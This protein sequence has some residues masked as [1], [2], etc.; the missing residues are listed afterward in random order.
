VT[1]DTYKRLVDSID[2][3]EELLAEEWLEPDPKRADW[4]LIAARSEF[5][6]R[7]F[8]DKVLA[9]VPAGLEG[10]PEAE[11]AAVRE[12]VV[13]LA[14]D[15][16]AVA[17]ASGDSMGADWV[18]S[19]AASLAAP[20]IA[21]ELTAARQELP[22]FV[23]IRH[24]AWLQR[25]GRAV[26]AAPRWMQLRWST[27]NAALL[28]AMRRAR[29]VPDAGVRRG[30]ALGR[31][32]GFGTGLYGAREKHGDGSYLSTLCLSA[33]WIPILPLA[34]YRVRPFGES[35]ELLGREPLGSMARLWASMTVLLA[36]GFCGLIGLA[37]HQSSPGYEFR[38]AMQRAQAAEK[39]GNTKG[40]ANQYRLAVGTFAGR[41]DVSAAV[42]AAVRLKAGVVTAPCRADS[43]PAVSELVTMF[44]AFPAAAR[45]AA[46]SERM[47][48]R[49]ETC[50][51]EI[52]EATIENTRA[53]LVVVEM[54]HGVASVEARARLS[55]RG[56]EM[57]RTL[58]DAL[59]VDRPLD[60]LFQHRELAGD[61][62]AR[63]SARK[64]L[65]GFGDASALWA[66]AAP[67]IRAW[68]GV[69]TPAAGAPAELQSRLE[70]A[71][72]A[73]ADFVEVA[74]AGNEQDLTRALAAHPGSHTLQIALAARRRAEGDARGCLRILN[75]LGV[76][77]RL[78]SSGR[79]LLGQ[80]LADTDDRDRAETVLDEFLEDRRVPFQ[81]ARAAYDSAAQR[82]RQSLNNRYDNGAAPDIAKA[83]KAAATAEQKNDLYESWIAREMAADR[84]LE[85]LRQSYV[86]FAS[87]VPASLTLGTLQLRRAAE[88]EGS[89][90]KALLTS[91]EKTFLSIR[92]EAGDSAEY[93]LGLGQVYHRLGKPEDG[94]RE[95]QAVVTLKDPE[96]TLH[97]AE[98]YR[99]LGLQ[100]R[101]RQLAEQVYN[102]RAERGWRYYAAS[103]MAHLANDL[104]EQALWL[105]R[106]DPA[107]PEIQLL[108]LEVDAER[109]MRDGD[110]GSADRAYMRAAEERDK[111]ASH[112][113]TALNNAAMAVLGRYRA[114]GEPA[115]LRGAIDRFERSVG[116]SADNTILLS[117]LGS[118]V[119]L[120]A[121]VEVLEKHLRTKPLLLS[122]GDASDLF[123]S[124]MHGSLRPGLLREIAGGPRLSRL[125]EVTRQEQILAPWR[126]EAYWLELR[127]LRWRGDVAG[128]ESLAR[129]VEALPQVDRVGK[130][131]KTPAAKATPEVEP[132]HEDETVA[133]RRRIARSKERLARASAARHAPTLAAAWM[134]HGD[135]LDGEACD[136][137]HIASC[138]AVVA[139]YRK[140]VELW[141]QAGFERDLASALFNKAAFEAMSAWPEMKT[142]W[143]SDD[144]RRSLGMFTYKTFMTPAAASRLAALR[145]NAELRESARLRQ[146]WAATLGQPFDW[147]LARLAGDAELERLSAEGLR[148]P[149]AVL[150]RRAQAVLLGA[151]SDE[152]RAVIAEA[153]RKH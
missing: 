88:A 69:G 89:E 7:T 74:R 110:Y 14:E 90:R 12:R 75:G 92:E 39:T 101:A 49:L 31:W 108:K 47:V 34:T 100:Q 59:A 5:V 52:G 70:Q 147:M 19:G 64:I 143:Q 126:N 121:V 46:P 105:S 32:L 8:R 1:A 118:A 115:H 84:N 48:E 93:R 28:R 43:I 45:S 2:V 38:E 56:V 3:S 11:A 44:R 85:G 66:D 78:P 73:E 16:A 67:E 140:A 117:N 149:D 81:R 17:A 15:V 119:E 95:L 103:K 83:M 135:V 77:G 20:E 152:L 111:L 25:R 61:A 87:I 22:V 13:R 40:A 96:H 142:A 125:G 109:K 71:Q 58:A 123:D 151:S 60:A 91:A 136:A 4:S 137:D 153:T 62:A 133:S 72:K 10:V 63:A 76:A 112:D 130:A 54:A 86:R 150:E 42:D 50:A 127:W 79:R 82:L 51:R 98:V 9:V 134:F 33:L 99:E 102:S 148:R 30:P 65:D 131:E 21:E 80:C 113:A 106:A 144:N 27:T 57:R 6:V 24:A 120:A 68:L 36:I 138:A 41:T 23:G 107:S 18:L 104:D 26:A 37:L 122:E 114:S 94:D 55:R 129:R 124:L 29:S 128:L 35:Y 132:Q 141:P 139:A 53:G 97:A 146:A 145:E 116:L